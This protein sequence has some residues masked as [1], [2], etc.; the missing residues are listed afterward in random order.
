[1]IILS[2]LFR[3]VNLGNFTFDVSQPN[4]LNLVCSQTVDY[5]STVELFFR[6]FN[7][8]ASRFENPAFVFEQHLQDCGLDS[9]QIQRYIA[10]IL[11]LI[12]DS[13]VKT[14]LKNLPTSEA[15]L[16]FYVKFAAW[17]MTTRVMH[18]RLKKRML[19]YE[20]KIDPLYRNISSLKYC[21]FML[22]LQLASRDKIWALQR[23]NPLLLPSPEMTD[24][25]ALNLKVS[26]SFY[27]GF[28]FWYKK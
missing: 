19:N 21:N 9:P 13:T 22:F 18:F 24:E 8:P 23:K 3:P 7:S 1:M 5:Y 10:S 17:G 12:D 25:F 6:L 26:F 16:R 20:G 14:Q 15:V 28:V 2:L 11:G 27:S 4:L